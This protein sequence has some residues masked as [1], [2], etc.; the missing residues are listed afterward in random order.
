MSGTTTTSPITGSTDLHLPAGSSRQGAWDVVV[1]P[2]SAGWGWTSLRVADVGP[3][4]RLVLDTGGEEVVLVPLRGGL[5]VTVGA[6]THRLDGR[7]S[8]LDGPTDVLYLPQGT[9]AVITARDAGGARVA[10]PG[11]LVG[12]VRDRLPVRRVAAAD[13]AVELRGA[14]TCTREVR[15][16]ASADVPLCYRLIAV[17]VITPGGSWSSYPPHKHDEASAVE[18]ELEEVYY[19]EVQPGPSGQPGVGYHRTSGTPERPVDVL[20]EVRDRDVVLVPHGWHGPCMAS[21]GNHLYYLNAMAGP[22][23]DRSWRIVDHPD[24]AWVRDTWA[25]Q[26]LDP[27][28]PLHETREERP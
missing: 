4:A 22:S 14:G 5:D 6:R 28:L 27:R 16:F 20:V 2:Q 12:D 18:S 23:Q 11:A 26:P 24:H 17:E 1:T 25:D 10:A 7:A 9:R 15:N 21:P 19:Y 13:V 3:G 8:V